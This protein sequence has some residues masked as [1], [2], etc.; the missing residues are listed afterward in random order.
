MRNFIIACI[1]IFLTLTSVVNA[2]FMVDMEAGLNLSGYNDVRV[3]GNIPGNTFSLQKL[4]GSKASSFFRARFT[5]TFAERHNISVLL[6]PFIKTYKGKLKQN[7]NFNGKNF[8]KD[9]ETTAKYKFNSWRLSYRWDFIKSNHFIV[10]IGLTGKIRDAEIKIKGKHQ[11][12]VMPIP[13]VESSKK[14]VGFVPLINFLFAWKITP[15]MDL[16]I[17]GDA[18]AAPQGRAEDI[19]IGWTGCVSEKAAL[20]IGYRF[21][22]GGADNNEVY[23]FALFHYIV[24][25]LMFRI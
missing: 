5:Y 9:F 18:L 16:R 2:Q 11:T 15:C 17:E 6:A 19:F 10:G 21:L 1:L 14:N 20:K 23:N 22:E 7:I 3:P 25:G 4:I 13:E 12:G 24:F 8:D